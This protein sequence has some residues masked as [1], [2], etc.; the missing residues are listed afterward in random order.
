MSSES[1]QRLNELARWK[2]EQDNLIDNM[3]KQ[4][5]GIEEEDTEE[6]QL[7]ASRQLSE[8]SG[9]RR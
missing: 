3:I 6:K 4:L 7:R 2:Q 8:C 9:V 1:T 5:G